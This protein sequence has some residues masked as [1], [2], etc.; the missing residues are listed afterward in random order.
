MQR[1]L[2]LLARIDGPSVVH[3]DMV[4]R[5]QSYRD[6]VRMC[7]ELRRVRGMNRKT[8]AEYAGIHTPHISDFLSDDASKRAMPA[9]Y[10]QSFETACGNTCISQWV[11]MQARLTVIEEMQARRSA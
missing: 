8:V 1:E 2:P 5:V 3:P 9:A 6:A 11:A 7:F 10:I 4:G